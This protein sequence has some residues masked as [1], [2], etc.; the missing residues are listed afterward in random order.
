MATTHQVYSNQV[1]KGASC[2]KQCQHDTI[3]EIERGGQQKVLKI[4]SA[5]LYCSPDYFATLTADGC[6][7]GTFRSLLRSLD[8][9]VAVLHRCWCGWLTVL[10][11][12]CAGFIWGISLSKRRIH[13]PW[14]AMSR[15]W[16]WHRLQSCRA[17][18]R[19]M[20]TS[21]YVYCVKL[22][23][24]TLHMSC[25]GCIP[26]AWTSTQLRITSTLRQ[27]NNDHLCKMKQLAPIHSLKYMHLYKLD[28]KFT[29]C[30]SRRERKN[31]DSYKLILLGKLLY[32][33]KQYRNFISNPE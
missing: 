31:S 26:R 4:S 16:D 2:M 11:Q 15:T 9:G 10:A 13:C 12:H 27:W 19:D 3:S 21:D 18:K 28:A 5:Q 30:F 7:V 14:W 25:F 1:R 33:E 22:V 29:T 8:Y 23:Y 6:F 32:V 17:W 24:W 20:G